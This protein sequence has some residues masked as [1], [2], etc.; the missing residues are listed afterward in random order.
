MVYF[1]WNA[2]G[3]KWLCMRCIWYEV[4]WYEVA[5]YGVHLVWSTTWYEVAWYEVHLVWSALGM[6]YH[7]VWSGLVWSAL[8]MKCTGMKCRGM[9]YLL[10]WSAQGWSDWYEVTF[11]PFGMKCQKKWSAG[12]MKCLGPL[13]V[14]DVTSKNYL[15]MVYVTWIEFTTLWSD[16]RYI[17]QILKLHLMGIQYTVFRILQKQ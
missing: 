12:G 14:A 15:F 11:F 3:M 5:W 13:T 10:G 6:K 7:L 17:L 9:K 8:G 2:L 4:A 1:V 16:V